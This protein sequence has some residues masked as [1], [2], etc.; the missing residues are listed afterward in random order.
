MNFVV[1]NEVRPPAKGFATFGALV[2]AGW[3]VHLLVVHQS[4]FEAKE[5]AT[6]A[7]LMRTSRR[8][9]FAVLS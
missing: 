9:N 1:S 5:V 4:R 3:A 8:V 7:A 6:A 2:G